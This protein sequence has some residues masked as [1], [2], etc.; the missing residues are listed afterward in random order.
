MAEDAVFDRVEQLQVDDQDQVERSDN[1]QALEED[2]DPYP[3]DISS[4]DD[5]FCEVL[6]GEGSLHWK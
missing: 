1:E 3:E 6:E 2:D 4:L 5:E